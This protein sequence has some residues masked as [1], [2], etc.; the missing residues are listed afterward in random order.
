MNVPDLPAVTHVAPTQP[1]PTRELRED[2]VPVAEAPRV[3][4][5][6]PA[7]AP[8]AAKP[9]LMGWIKSLFAEGAPAA[10]A[11]APAPRPERSERGDRNS[12]RGNEQR[13]GRGGQ[14]QGGTRSTQGSNRPQ[15][16]VP[17]AKQQGQA[18]PEP[19]A[20]KPP[21]EPRPERNEDQKLQDEQRKLETQR[22]EAERREN[23]RQE[24]IKREAERRAA[25]EAR[26]AAQ[27]GEPAGETSDGEAVVAEHAVIATGAVADGL[28]TEADGVVG[29]GARR[30][31][32]RRGGRRRRRQ[33]GTAAGEAEGTATSQSEIDFDDEEGG[34]EF[35]TE[36]RSGPVASSNPVAFDGPVFAS[37]LPVT[38]A[39]SEFDDLPLD[40]PPAVAATQAPV[41]R[42]LAAMEPVGVPLVQA[43]YA[44]PTEPTPSQAPLVSVTV[45]PIL[46]SL[47]V[48]SATIA[49]ADRDFVAEIEDDVPSST[50]AAEIRLETPVAV[51]SPARAETV[52]VVEALAAAEDVEADATLEAA[53]GTQPDEA[54]PL[55]KL[56]EQSPRPASDVP[57]ETRNPPTV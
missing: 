50:E 14:P 40:L 28:A 6:A 15:S 48:E 34:E 47:P 4:R 3:P 7:A 53:E 8:A 29:E 46:N 44:L 2:T 55:S 45:Q 9:G 17:A 27:P 20:A 49:P 57:F 56:A 21:R 23:Q 12:S 1:A 25:R 22:K 18:K 32:G 37:G 38:S 11:P 41:Q 31:R 36:Q 16:P 5:A 51:Q 10:P 19:Q 26:L 54:A 39:E 52:S 30:R 42:E 13:R 43:S 33:E 35:E 24:N